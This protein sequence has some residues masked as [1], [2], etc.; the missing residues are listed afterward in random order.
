MSTNEKE[1]AFVSFYD[2]ETQL[3]KCCLVPR[4]KVRAAIDHASP[5]SIPLSAPDDSRAPITDEDARHLGGIALVCHT[6]LHPELLDRLQ[7]TFAAPVQWT[8]VARP[9]VD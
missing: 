1:I 3:V 6:K 7:I 9:S 8:P 4:H 2:E 5:V